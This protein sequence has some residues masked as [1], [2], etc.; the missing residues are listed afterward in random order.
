[1]PADDPFS[2]LPEQPQPQAKPK[3]RDWREK[4][5]S[6][7]KSKAAAQTNREIADFL[8]TSRAPEPAPAPPPNDPRYVPPQNNYVPPDLSGYQSKPAAAPAPTGPPY[9]NYTTA[10]FSDRQHAPPPAPAPAK[11][12][13]RKGKGLRVGFSNRTPDVIGEGGDESEQPTI[14]I[15]WTLRKPQ[16]GNQLG[17]LSQNPS[18]TH[19]PDLR[20]DT[21]LGDGE[22]RPRRA[23]SSPRL[24]DWKPPLMQNMQ[25][26]DFLR[27]LPLSESGS[28]LSFRGDSEESAFAQRVRDK[29]QAEEGR[30]LHHRYDEDTSSPGVDDDDLSTPPSPP[31]PEPPLKGHHDLHD[32]E[33]TYDTAPTSATSHAPSASLSMMSIVDSI[34]NPPSPAVHRAPAPAPAPAPAS[35]SPID[36]RMPPN[37]I[38]GSPGKVSPTLTKP[39]PQI[40]PD[41]THVAPPSGKAQEPPKE[42]ARSSQPKF[43]IRNIANQVGDSAF[44][45]F[46][47]YTG[48]YE[49]MI[50]LAAESVKPLMETS[51]SEWVRAA[52]WWFLRG[53]TRLE[54]YARSRATLP[55]SFAKQAVIDLGK[56]LWITENIVPSHSELTRYGSMSIDSLIA[57]ASTTGDKSLADHLSMH[58]T[59]LNHL[60]S[61]SMSIKRNNILA[62]VVSDEGSPTQLDTT[63][64][65]RYPFYAPDVSAVLSGAATRSMLA[66]TTAKTPSLVN[67]MPLSDTGRYF[68]Y[69]TLF[70]QVCVSSSDDDG[71]QQY[72]MPCALT[73][74]RERSDWY[75][76]AAITSQSQLVNIMIQSDRKQGPTWDDVEWQ[77]RSNS[78]RAKLPRGFELDVM[79]KEE[80]F[81]TLWNIVKYTKKSEDSLHPEA[82]ETVVFENT[83]KSFQYMDPGTPKAFPPDPV[84]RC[85]VRLFERSVT[86]TEGTGTRNAHRGFRMAVLT[87]PRVKTLSSIRHTLG[88]GSPVVFGLLRG[89]NGAPALL[90]KVTE[91]GR[92]RSML[93]TFHEV[94]ERA[95]LHSVLLGMLP[96]N[97]EL[98][99]PE[100]ALTSYCIEQPEDHF[101]GRPSVKHLEFPAGS[102]CVIDQEHAY[103]DHG[104]GPTILSE[105]LRA[106][107]ATE[108]GSVTDRINLGPGELKVGLDVK[109]PT[110]MSLFRPAQQDLTLSLADNLVA[111]ELPGKMAGLLEK[112]TAKP[113]I[114]RFD[115]PTMQDLHAFE[116]AVTGFKVLYDG[117]ASSFS[118]SRRRSMVPIYKKWEA[119]LARVQIVRQE[120]VVQLLAFFGEFQHGTCMNF[121]LKGT[122]I[123]ES[124]GRSGKFGIR[125]VDAKFALPRKDEDPVSNFVCLDMPEYPIEHDDIAITFETEAARATFKAALPG[126]SRA[127]GGPPGSRGLDYAKPDYAGFPSP[128]RCRSIIF[129]PV[130]HSNIAYSTMSSQGAS[131]RSLHADDSL[132]VVTDVSPPI[133]LSTTFRYSNDPSKLVPAADATFDPASTSHIYS[134]VSAPNSTR[135]EMILS[136]LLNG[137]AVSYSSGLSALHGALTLLNPRNISVGEGYHGCHG[138]IG[139]FTRNTG[140]RKLPLDCPAESLEKGDVILLETPV[141]PHG[142][143]FDIA[144]FAAKA[145]SRGAI[146]IVDSTFAPPGLQEPFD[147]G[148]DIIMHSGTKYFGGHSDLLS[149]VLATKN[150]EW[151]TQLKID[152]LYIGSVMGNLESWLGVRSLRTLEVRL[153]RQSENASKLVSWLDT[154]LR[155][156]NP[157]PGSDESAV[158]AVL[159]SISHASLQ[160]GGDWLKKQM[161]NGFGPVFSINMKEEKFARTLPSLLHFFQ[162]ATSLGGVETLIEW[163][164]MSDTTVERT[165]LRISVGLENW[166]D[167]RSDLL[168]A[169]KELAK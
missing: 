115:F 53:K 85:R 25:D 94:E 36:P 109:R 54:V 27:T 127:S 29:M 138:V 39:P 84:E 58:Q 64:W 140:L 154:S 90:L 31:S 119:S 120:K 101:S 52:V 42:A 67:M 98:K 82:G 49:S 12:H 117:M 163:R 166:E 139:L 76:C 32:S 68:S 135:F 96:R 121:V 93:M 74:V 134:R 61:L 167:L 59:A 24:D 142:T 131:T 77:V 150:E 65:L 162:H 113:M 66:D 159:G 62:S 55:P 112:I 70:V 3:K 133:H 33:S 8:S 44:A 91:D 124:F 164:T 107:V 80:D 155:A 23:G 137:H 69:G 125:M 56:A 40:L 20:L 21:S 144:S 160:D 63:I 37:L 51:L 95:E 50:Q 123:M 57:V 161:P 99:S 152:R 86:I 103:V 34:R 89:E 60:R 156:T 11:P 43:S 17:S 13:G 143:A 145:H 158:Q 165:L 92:T 102:V 38:P 114:R 168:D 14:E 83:V 4:L 35:L 111:P 108:W 148:A 2:F 147:F 153:Q 9:E 41:P 45:E 19:L 18:R 132:N 46:K 128:G 88:N 78:M 100:I 5:F 6:K 104:Y 71:Q 72:A 97:G 118:I 122:D 105:N 48:R 22:S 129:E 75:V 7:D 16:G 1:M 47:E 136:S 141:N 146:L 110:S 157:S 81:K 30:A 116:A 149:G 10:E 126:S 169:F 106:F 151:A 26:S 73:I 79:F 130:V 28:R 87:S 15:S